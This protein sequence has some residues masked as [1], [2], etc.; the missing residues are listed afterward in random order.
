[1]QRELMPLEK[2]AQ[3]LGISRATMWR[4]VKEL[5]L[6][7]YTSPIDKRKRLLDWEEIEEATRPTPTKAS[8]RRAS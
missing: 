3:R 2:A 7:V 6:T 8:E 1:M 4:R 5:R